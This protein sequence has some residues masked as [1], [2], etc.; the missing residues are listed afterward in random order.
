MNRGTARWCRY[1][2][3]ALQKPNAELVTEPIK[4]IEPGGILTADGQSRAIDAIVLATGYDAQNT[5]AHLPIHGTNGVSLQQHWAE[6]GKDALLGTTVNGFPNFFLITGPH[7]GGGH[8]SQIFM[9]EAQVHYIAQALGALRSARR[10]EVRSQA[11]RAFAQDMDRRMDRSVWKGG[12]CMSWFLDPATGR[13][14]LLWP[15][16][17]SDYWLKTRRLK[18]SDY[19]IER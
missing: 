13:N 8:N 10:I 11:Q 9:I 6:H 14:T 7:S 18:R 1:R 19:R 2:Y 16:Y 17:S 15:S 4:R 5:H 12:G 3:P